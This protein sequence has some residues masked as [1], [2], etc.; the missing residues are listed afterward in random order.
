SRLGVPVGEIE[1]VE[2]DTAEVPQG[3]GTFGSRSIA[4]GGSALDRAAEKIIA[5]GK[6]IAGHL[7][8]AAPGDIEFADG[9]FTVAGTDR[10][11]AFAAVAAAAYAAQI[12]PQGLEP[13]LQDTAVYDPPN[14]AFSNGVHICEI[15]IDP[16]TR[17]IEPIGF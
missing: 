16:D 3:T 13:G 9:A 8:E 10:R 14:F 11:I 7:L 2:G 5:K 12:L 4:I 17:R 1:I 15:E 6:L